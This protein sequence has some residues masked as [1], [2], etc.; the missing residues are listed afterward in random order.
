M[1][2]NSLLRILL[3]KKQNWNF[4]VALNLKFKFI[5]L[6]IQLT[7]KKFYFVK[8][9][10]VTKLRVIK[11]IR[12]KIK[13]QKSKIEN[14]IDTYFKVLIRI[15]IFNKKKKKDQNL[16][17]L[18]IFSFLCVYFCILLNRIRQQRFPTVWSVGYISSLW[19]DLIC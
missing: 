7:Y 6:L 13:N 9:L 18:S 8:D 5:S 17:I 11:S 1:K 12:N 15:C 2:F 19:F 14:G 3:I 16:L 10:L 4:R